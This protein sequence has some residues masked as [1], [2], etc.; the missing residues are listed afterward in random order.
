MP[1]GRYIAIEVKKPSE[2]QFFDKTLVELVK[3]EQEAIKKG[4]ARLSVKKYTHAVEQ[5]YFLDQKI[6]KGGI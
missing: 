5:R 4:I 1:N 6:K 2:M 3:R